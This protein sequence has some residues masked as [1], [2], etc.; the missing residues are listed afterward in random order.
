VVAFTKYM[1]RNAEF[2]VW[3]IERIHT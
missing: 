2:I 3:I 1:K